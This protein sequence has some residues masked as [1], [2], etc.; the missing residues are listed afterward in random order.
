MS[1]LVRRVLIISKQALFRE[2]LRRLLSD[3]SGIDRLEGVRSLNDA[4]MLAPVMNPDL[5]IFDCSDLPPAEIP[6]EMIS[7]LFRLGS[8]QVVFLT[9]ANKQ[10]VLYSRHAFREATDSDL[11]ALLENNKR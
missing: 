9:L 3:S 5:I 2:G 8:P 6:E 4:K 1:I 7:N 11:L 10:M